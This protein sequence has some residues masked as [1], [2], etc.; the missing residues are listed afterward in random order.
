MVNGPR[1]PYR[2]P[3][4]PS[5]A[6]V[7]PKKLPLHPKRPERVCWGCDHYCAAGDLRCGN[8]SDRAQHPAEL[9]G[10]D[11]LELGLDATIV[12]APERPVRSDA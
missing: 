12:F 10:D 1:A 6:T 3:A 2:S 5:E 11:W 9:F 8:G 4:R 7:V